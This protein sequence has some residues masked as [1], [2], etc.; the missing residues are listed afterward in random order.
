MHLAR[1]HLKQARSPAALALYPGHSLPHE[2]NGRPARPAGPLARRKLTDKS[3]L[4]FVLR[5]CL[6]VALAA[7]AVHFTALAGGL[8]LPAPPVR[9]EAGGQKLAE[10][11]RAAMPETNSEIHGLLLVSSGKTK[12][13]IPVL[14]QVKMREGAWETIYQAEATATAGAERLVIIHSANGPNQYLYARAAKPGA[15]LPELSPVLPEA[16]EAPFAGSDFSVGDLGLEFLH[17]PGQCELLPREQR[18]GQPCYVL[19]ST[20][21][22]KAGIVRVKS[23]ID[24]E[25]PGPL[26]AEAYD[27]EGHEIKEFS[28]DH[29]SFKK[30]ARGHWQ[31]EEMGIDNKKTHSHTDLKFD[32]PKDQ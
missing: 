26:V 8:P 11:M 22:R 10:Q 31:L 3:A 27:S 28:L 14:C 1:S 2:W 18:L 13:R 17:W 32:M 24:E 25:T 6:A 20:N 15:P 23:W 9:D 5:G 16:T 12:S 4:F 7:L 21:S 29:K 30:D 19:E